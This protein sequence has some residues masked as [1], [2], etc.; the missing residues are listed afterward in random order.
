MLCTRTAGLVWLQK[1]L[2]VV[3]IAETNSLLGAL[4]DGLAGKFIA[5]HAAQPSTDDF[6]LLIVSN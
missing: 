4:P 3:V 1:K 2:T 5:M 6:H